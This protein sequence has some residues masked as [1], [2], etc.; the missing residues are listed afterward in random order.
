M[1]TLESFQDKGNQWLTVG[2]KWKIM[3]DEETPAN[4]FQRKQL[5][6]K[7]FELVVFGDSITKRIDPF[8]IAKCDKWLALN[9]SVGGAKVRGVYEQIRTFRENH[10]E[11][12]V[13]NVIIHTD[14]NHLL[15]DHPSDITA[16]ISKLLLHERK[17]FQLH[18]FTFP[19]PYL[20]LITHFFK[21]LIMWI[22]KYSNCV[23]T[24]TSYV[25]PNTKDLPK[26]TKWTNSFSGKIWSIWGT[27]VYGN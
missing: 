13:T 3:H 22:V 10:E 23:P 11:A 9:Y 25:S 1:N 12:A 8:F 4:S 19:Q 20:T 21:W 16:K 17:N 5:R 2:K 24:T 7:K 6:S 15:R 18:R 27:T 26:I 14:T